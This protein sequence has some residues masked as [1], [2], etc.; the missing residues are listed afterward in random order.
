[1]IP[2]GRQSISQA[3]IDAVVEVLRSDWLTQGPVL[4]RFE[5]AV[6][7]YCGARYAVA[8]SSATAALHL[9]CL[10]AGLGPGGRLWTSPVTFVAS[11]NC[12]R[13]CGAE[14]GFVDI[15]S[16]D[17]NLA[18]ATLQEKLRR[19]GET[20]SLPQV[21][22]PVHLSGRSCRMDEIRKL[23]E[24]KNIVII[25]DAS[26]A[27]GG[28][29]LG[30]P[31]GSCQFSDMTV[32]SF[33]PV[34]IVTS[35]EGGMIVTNNEKLH[36]RLVRLRSH[37][38][39][40]NPAEMVGENHGSWYYQQI[41]L[42]FNYR[43]TEIQAALGCSQMQRL[44]QF[45]ERRNYLAD[46]YDR[47]LS[48]LPLRLPQRHADVRSAFH[49]Y[50]IRLLPGQ[51]GKNRAQVFEELRRA[52]IGVNVH[53][54]PVH[55]QPYYRGLGFGDGDFPVAEAYYRDAISLPLFFDLTE[56][57]QDKVVAALGAILA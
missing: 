52:D 2:Y 49:L 19:A 35:G 34:K 6:A 55:T 16:E 33:H 9:A 10:A 25:E 32:F 54:I 42:G 15:D 13:Y 23:T 24:E 7:D 36:A 3:D 46:R 20:D 17:G 56:A 47:L 50:V 27:L 51:G 28:R 39:T 44:D 14:V 5:N 8:V 22:V 12:G 57:D 29:Y 18:P 4:E 31:V 43:M 37:G 1:M 38:I 48:G 41:E 40:R 53:Y 30:R 45:V 11:A 26:H 21:L